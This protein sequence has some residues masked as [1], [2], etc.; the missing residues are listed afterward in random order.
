[1]KMTDV[2][3]A[4]KELKDWI[5]RA[6]HS[7]IEHFKKLGHKIKRHRDHIL[8]TIRCRMSNAR[9]EAINNKIKLIVR[10]AFGFRNINNLISMALLTCSKIYIPFPWERNVL[11]TLSNQSQ[12]TSMP[13][14]PFF[15]L[16][17]FWRAHSENVKLA[18][19]SAILC[20]SLSFSGHF[21]T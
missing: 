1:M 16:F 5:W 19:F 9:I 15:T 3:K 17:S 21:Y 11:T 18:L 7:R 20:Q 13:E 10:K 8:N 12:P 6:T 14:E 2:E 4:G